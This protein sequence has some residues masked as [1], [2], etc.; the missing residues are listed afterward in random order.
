MLKLNKKFITRIERDKQLERLHGRGCMAD[1]VIVDDSDAIDAALM[2]I[3]H[4]ERR[5]KW[6]LNSENESK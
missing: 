2:S 5:K 6:L 4:E 1:V 3:E